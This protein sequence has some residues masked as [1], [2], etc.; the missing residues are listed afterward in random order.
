MPVKL[1]IV[2]KKP[3][4]E[5]Q[6]ELFCKASRFVPFQF[7]FLF[8]F[9]LKTNEDPCTDCTSADLWLLG[10]WDLQLVLHCYLQTHLSICCEEVLWNRCS[11]LKS[12]QRIKESVSRVHVMY[13]KSLNTGKGFCL[14]ELK[15]SFIWNRL[16]YTVQ[17]FLQKKRM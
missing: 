11:A 16:S 15:L 10:V 13:F 4:T 17:D 14:P 3:T 2:R 7:S 5:K 6:C 12:Q 1:V 8:D 9:I